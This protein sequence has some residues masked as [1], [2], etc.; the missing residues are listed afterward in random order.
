MTFPTIAI[1]GKKR[2]VVTTEERTSYSQFHPP[3]PCQSKP[4]ES[5]RP[6]TGKRPTNFARGKWHKTHWLRRLIS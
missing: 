3:L 4:D 5:R 6:K 2:D 1:A